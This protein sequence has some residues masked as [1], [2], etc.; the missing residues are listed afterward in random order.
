MA[1]TESNLKE[2]IQEAQL[3]FV[4]S[5]SRLL[6]EADEVRQNRDELLKLLSQQAE[7]DGK[8]WEQPHV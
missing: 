5:A 4:T 1:T 8:R 2:R 7:L 3:V 6:D